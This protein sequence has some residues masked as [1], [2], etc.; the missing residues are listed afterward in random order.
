M[1]KHYMMYKRGLM[2][3]LAIVLAISIAGC[4]TAKTESEGMTEPAMAQGSPEAVA[5]ADKGAM[6]TKYPLTVK[7]ASGTELIFDKAPE[8]ITT[9]AASET[10]TVFA[11]GA[12]D[13]VFG[14]DKYS[15]YPVEAK[16]KPQVGDM[17]TNLEALIATKPDVVFA[18][19]T[20]QTEIVNKLRELNI[21][22]YASDPKTI[23]EVIAKIETVG[24]ILN[25]QANAHKV[26]DTMRAEKQK[27]VDVLKD[28]PKKKVYLEF[29]PGWTVGDGEFLSELVALAGGTNVASG[30]K[31]WYK[32]D[33]EAII[34]ANPEVI[35]YTKPAEGQPSILDEINKRSGWDKID[36]IQKKQIFGLE[37]DPLVRVGP[38]ITQGLLEVAKA[39][40][41]ELVK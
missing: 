22:V 17:K 8:R 40:H 7:D 12:G 23:D 27:V 41:P 35:L 19:Y 14:V 26:T 10:E 13:K 20:L 34:K 1:N 16:S 18:G 5:L 24:Q 32:I 11:L 37:M 2:L 25:L 36:A 33:P 9:L 3:L 29:D 4:G 21:K 15:N 30:Q 28:A 6:Q 39:V 31:G 38:R